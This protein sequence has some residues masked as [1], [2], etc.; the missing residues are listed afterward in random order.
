MIK[1]FEQHVTKKAKTHLAS[2]IPELAANSLILIS[3][4]THM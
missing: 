1:T 2:T 4:I 3:Q